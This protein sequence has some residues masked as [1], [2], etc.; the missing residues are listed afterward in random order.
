MRT[1]HINIPDSLEMS[2]YDF[3]MM[4]AAKLY[5][6]KLSTGQAAEM[7][8]LSKRSFIE[9]LGKYGVSLFSSSIN[10]LHSDIANA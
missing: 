8:G 4:V 9:V 5:E 3:S 6:K 2:D 7:V 1:I 10:D